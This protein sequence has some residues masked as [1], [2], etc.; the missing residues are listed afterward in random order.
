MVR[1][2]KAERIS[3]CVEKLFIK[4]CSNPSPDVLNALKK[5]HQSERAPAAREALRQILKNAQI[6]REKDMPCC[7]DTGMAVV[8][9]EIGQDVHIT[10]GVYEAVNTGVKNAYKNG[11][12]RKSV[13]DPVT[14]E[15]TNDNTP[16]VIH[17]D[18]VPGN[19]VRVT[20][21]PKG[22]GSENM[23]VLS[24][25]K[26]AEGMDGIRRVV[27]DAVKRAGGSPC[28]PVV[29]GIG[30]GGTMEKAA[31]IAKRQLLRETGSKNPD[32]K[33]SALEKELKNSINALGM[34]AMGLDGDT[35][36]LA[37]H[38]QTFPTH[39]AG[40]PVAVNFQCHAARHET[41]VI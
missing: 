40:L 35:Y 26:P 12:L 13:L 20:A 4:A 38:I 19:K 34:G 6:A 9:L 7:Q 39:L 15:N 10:G 37:V 30:I 3:E 27:I 1:E 36:C 21:V 41:A 29:L 18:I 2:L 25:L 28:P 8:F 32:P 5:A 24:M 14:R 23:S 31:L 17:T 16:A 22:F 33:L 11:Y